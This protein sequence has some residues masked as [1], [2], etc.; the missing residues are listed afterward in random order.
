[1]TR[2][3]D[4]DRFISQQ[5]S[6]VEQAHNA[7]LTNIEKGRADNE[8]LIRRC[9]KVLTD[10]YAT[11]LAPRMDLAVILKKKEEPNLDPRKIGQDHYHYLVNFVQPDLPYRSHH[12]DDYYK[13]GEIGHGHWHPNVA[14]Q[15]DYR[16]KD[17]YSQEARA[18]VGL[19]PWIGIRGWGTIRKDETTA[20]NPKL[21]VNHGNSWYLNNFLIQIEGNPQFPEETTALV[22]E[23]LTIVT[24]NVL[25]H[26][27]FIRS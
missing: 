11:I 17:K 2:F 7:V 14:L 12:S 23:A 15:F 27:Q 9:F 1:M 10:Y 3:E 22:E 24:P 21:Y 13:P 25:N 6:M 26:R 20:T 4:L 16:I 19:E 5:Q 8:P 18:V